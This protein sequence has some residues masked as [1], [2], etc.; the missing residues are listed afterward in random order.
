MG[1]RLLAVLVP[2]TT[3]AN[4]PHHA[5]AG[6][7]FPL[8]IHDVIDSYTLGGQVTGAWDP[9]YDPTMDS[10][11]W[12]P[13][14][15]C[16][17]TRTGRADCTACR[18]ATQAGRTPGTELTFTSDWAAHP[19]D[20]VA[21]GRLLDPGWRFPKGRTPIGWV[22]LSGVVWLDTELAVL[23]GTGTD[24]GDVPP[25]LRAVFDDLIAGRRAHPRKRQPF[26]V[27]DYALAIVDAAQLTTHPSGSAGRF[28]IHVRKERFR[29]MTTTPPHPWRQGSGTGCGTAAPRS[30]A[31]APP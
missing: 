18:D 22:D 30:D 28:P 3:T 12:R 31:T 26:N 5:L 21:L 17:G 1:H 7:L 15:V 9:S 25:R 29:W 10:R 13:C 2:A 8:V 23:T 24:T 19:G 14:A 20:I 16:G 11:N 27:A 4:S 6:A